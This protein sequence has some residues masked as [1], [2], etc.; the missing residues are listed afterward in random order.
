M[1]VTLSYSSP[2]ITQILASH[3]FFSSQDPMVHPSTHSNLHQSCQSS[4]PSTT[5][6]NKADMKI[7]LSKNPKAN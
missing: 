3:P 2:I 7:K 1:P 4:H 5:L 6:V